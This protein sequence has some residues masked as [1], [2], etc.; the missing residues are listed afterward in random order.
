MM[1]FT[2]P[3]ITAIDSGDLCREHESHRL[4][5]RGRHV[6]AQVPF[7]IGPQAQQASFRGNETAFS[8]SAHAG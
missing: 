1:H 3:L 7:E 4:L 6:P 5:A 2:C 8:S